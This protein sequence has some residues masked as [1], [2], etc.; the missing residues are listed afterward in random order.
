MTPDENAEVVR[1]ALDD[2]NRRDWRAW[3]T[4][5]HGD[6]V[7]VPHRDWP[8]SD[9]LDG[10]SRGASARNNSGGRSRRSSRRRTPSVADRSELHPIARRARH[11]RT[12]ASVRTR[13]QRYC[14][15]P[16]C[17]LSGNRGTLRETSSATTI[18]RRPLLLLNRLRDR[19]DH[20]TA[21]G[22]DP[23]RIAHAAGID[24]PLI[25]SR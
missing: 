24:Q 22:T 17:S 16:D 18:E 5:H 6:M 4:E 15:G 20:G 8:E 10:S 1:R 23:V 14:H 7:A 12:A 2:W 25:G 3:V 11:P 13:K 19:W 9:P 21:H